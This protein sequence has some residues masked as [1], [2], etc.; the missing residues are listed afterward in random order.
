MKA[1]AVC[2]TKSCC[3]LSAMDKPVLFT[4]TA[5]L[6]LVRRYFKARLGKRFEK[7]FQPFAD[8][9][10]ALEWCENRLL[11]KNPARPAVPPPRSG[12]WNTSCVKIS[13]WA[14]LKSSPA[15]QTA[16]LQAR[17]NYH[18]QRGRGPGDF[19]ARPR[20]RECLRPADRRRPAAARHFF[21]RDGFWRDGRD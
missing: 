10:L 5:H 8:N 21:R 2:F 3:K 19:S 13:R 1:P 4:H 6:Q 16:K 15:S 14:N 20:R 7:L 18:P 12:S 11:R 17:R 9:D